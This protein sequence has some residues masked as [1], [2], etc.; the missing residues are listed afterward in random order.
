MIDDPAHAPTLGSRVVVVAG[1][2]G[3]VGRAVVRALV[4]AGARVIVPTRAAA[5]ADG[6]VETTRSG[7]LIVPVVSWA[8]P[9]EIGEVARAHG[10]RPDAA[11][12]SLGGW[13]IGT[14]LVDLTP[15]QWE[16]LIRDHL[17]SHFLAARAL[18]PLIVGGPDP[19]YVALNG[20]AS[21]EAMAGSGPVSVAGAGQR[22]LLDV[23]RRED[24]GSAVRFHEVCVRAAVA[25]DDR[26]LDPQT[27]VTGEQVADAVLRVLTD[28]AAPPE[29]DVG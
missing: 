17:T 15:E 6:A 19:V 26:N 11:V 25:G 27:E 14:Q 20:A 5:A 3:V 10:W 29:C 13:W 12:A 1:G 16:A 2:T 21:R 23:L 22:M 8:D 9:R 18:A 28:P 7:V 4:A 24:L